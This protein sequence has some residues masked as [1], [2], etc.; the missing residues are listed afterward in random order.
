MLL[1]ESPEA[2]LAMI[3]NFS[4][5]HLRLAPTLPTG[6]WSVELNSGDA[7]W[8]AP[9]FASSPA[10]PEDEL[11]MAPHAFVVLKDRSPSN[12]GVI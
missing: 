7:K 5:G 12:Q 4:A 10:P 3:F 9:P 8:L 1:R 6:D 11:F 2:R